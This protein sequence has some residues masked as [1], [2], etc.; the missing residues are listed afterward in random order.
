[1]KK[2]LK[3][4]LIIIGIVI[5]TIICDTT[6]AKLFNNTPIIKIV[7][8]YN[9][10]TLYQKHIGLLVDTYVKTDGTKVTVF[11]WDCDSSIN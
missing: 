6:Q 1:M 4:T 3:I 5:A 7:E 10:G 2:G 9:G 11:K 8:D